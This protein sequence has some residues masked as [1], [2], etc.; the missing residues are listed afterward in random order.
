MGARGMAG[1]LAPASHRAFWYSANPSSQTDSSRG[2]G[3]HSET[4][5]EFS[6]LGEDVGGVTA[7]GSAAATAVG[8][9]GTQ[10]LILPSAPLASGGAHTPTWHTWAPWLGPCP[11]LAALSLIPETPAQPLALSLLRPSSSSVSQSRGSRQ[12]AHG[13]ALLT[14]PTCCCPIQ[15]HSVMPCPAGDAVSTVHQRAILSIPSPRPLSTG[16][17]WDEPL[18]LPS[19]ADSGGGGGGGHRT[20][21]ILCHKARATSKV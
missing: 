2:H 15:R 10:P 16:W 12:P 4:V 6:C 11:L 18:T 1:S 21:I 3:C 7:S 5:A 17:C 9:A 8:T 19:G 20:Q 13:P 14:A